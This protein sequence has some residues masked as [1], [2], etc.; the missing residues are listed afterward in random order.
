MSSQA[1]NVG[2]GGEEGG[3]GGRPLNANNYFWF[4]IFVKPPLKGQ[5]WPEMAKIRVVR[6]PGRMK[7]S[8]AASGLRELHGLWPNFKNQ[9]AGLSQLEIDAGSTI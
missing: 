6:I 3:E 1:V 2:R 8:H 7:E 4:C 5:F 9:S